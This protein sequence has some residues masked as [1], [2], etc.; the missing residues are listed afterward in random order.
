MAIVAE[1]YNDMSAESPTAAGSRYKGPTIFM[2][3]GK[4]SIA[5]TATQI[6]AGADFVATQF[7]VDWSTDGVNFIPFG[8]TKTFALTNSVHP[9]AGGLEPFDFR[10][11]YVRIRP[12]GVYMTTGGGGMVRVRVFELDSSSTIVLGGRLS[13]PPDGTS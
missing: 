11:P 6:S 12:T 1:Q 2:V 10:L 5:I 3:S 9:P 7:T 8:A 4:T 13:V